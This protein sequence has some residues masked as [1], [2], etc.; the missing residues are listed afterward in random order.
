MSTD[1]P[2]ADIGQLRHWITGVEVSP[3][4]NNPNCK[5]SARLFVDSELVCNLPWIDHT[6][7]F[8]WSGILPC[9]TS[10]S[11]VALRLCR[12]I[13]DKS[14]YFNF[15]AFT[16]SEVDETGDS[17]IELP[18]AAWI[19]TVKSLTP[20]L[21][22][23]SYPAEIGKFNSIEGVYNSSEPDG[24]A[25]YLF[26]HAL[27]FARLALS[28][29]TAKV[30]FLICMKTWELLDQQT[31]LDEMVK[32][33][34]DGLNCI[35]DINDTISQA[36]SS[37]L[38]TAMDQS[39][40]AINDILALLEDISVYIFNRY[41]RNELVPAPLDEAEPEHANNT[42]AYVSRLLDLQQEFHT[43]WSPELESQTNLNNAT[44]EQPNGPWQDE[45][46]PV[47][48]S[49]R[50]TDWCELLTLLKPMDPSGYDH[51]QGCM[52]GTR[53]AILSEIVAW[54]QRRASTE[55]FMW[56]SGQI[57]MG[58]T[59]IAHSLCQRLDKMRALAASFFYRP[60]DPNN[61]NPLLLFNNLICEIAMHCPAYARVAAEAIRAKPKLC[62]SHFSLRYEGLVKRPL[63]QLKSLPMLRSLVVVVDG[64]DECSDRDARIRILDKLYEMA[65]LVPWL[66]VIFTS[67]PVGDIQE[68]YQSSFLRG[69][70]VHIQQYDA[71]PDIRAYIEDQLGSF[72]EDKRWP[73]EGINQLCT[74]AQGV[75]LW[76]TLAVG[77]IRKS[78]L[79]TS[80]RLNKVLSNQKSPVTDHFD[81]LYSRTL[82]SL[83]DNEDDIKSAYLG[84]I[85]AVL[86]VS[87]REPLAVPDL[88]YLLL[89]ADR[90]DQ[91]VLEQILK[92]LGPL[93]LSTD[94]RRIQFYH[95]SFR[96]FITSS[97]RSGQFHIR[98]NQYEA[99]PAA[100]CLAVMQRDL[101]FNICG[102]ETSHVY[103]SEVP[104]LEDRMNTQIQPALKYACMHWIDHFMASPNQVLVEAINK[105]ITSPQLM[106][107]IEVLSL[108]GH[109][110]IAMSGL[111]KL[112]SLELPQITE[113]GLIGFWIKDAHR[114]LLSFYDVIATSTPHLY[115]SALAF[116]PSTSATAN[117][118]RPFFPNTIAVAQGG[119]LYWHPCIKSIS[120]QQT[121]QSLS[122]SPDGLR[123]IAGY[124]DGSLC[125]WDT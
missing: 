94:G 32:D 60:D 114:F 40:K 105:F 47:D 124:P 18:E 34:L 87:E 66:K 55:S 73:H 63:E 53:E 118:M 67:C 7:P 93:L 64:L 5:F 58:K 19:I 56:I 101:R 27:Q 72:A 14:R 26:K 22:E 36:Q 51:D 41:T 74:M 121:I 54:T 78:K 98:P 3:E 107:W 50:T 109:V 112:M 29:S 77:Y 115:I 24:T 46:T 65:T 99:D 48:E 57:G 88:Q 106:Y 102:L 89:V 1:P 70:I 104:D 80:S 96:D 37:I 90:I 52:D 76:A 10:H 75:F 68:H 92:G 82:R 21:A 30:T 42:E 43:S 4:N 8:R 84:C 59:A 123:F 119:R 2:T 110:D 100:C 71:S 35:R 31:E 62:T 111:S 11:E 61:A 15:P 39:K 113:W 85:G 20:K 33:I 95:T 116:A 13:R 12:S 122:I 79:Q 120:H 23:H 91:T 81:A 16:I 69:S 49:E 103:N 117:R 125:I 25:K 108:M 38:A 6:Q 86:A 97:S 83:D 45:H 44:S 17:I 28:Q 9:D